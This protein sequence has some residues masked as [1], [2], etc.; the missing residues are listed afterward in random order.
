MRRRASAERVPVQMRRRASLERLEK[1]DAPPSTSVCMPQHASSAEAVRPL[2]RMKPP[3]DA[4]PSKEKVKPSLP[5]KPSPDKK[6]DR[7]PDKSP[8]A[9]VQP[10]PRRTM[11]RMNSTGKAGASQEDPPSPPR[12]KKEPHVRRAPSKT[13]MFLNKIRP[14]RS[15][16]SWG[17]GRAGAKAT[18]KKS[19]RKTGPV[20]PAKEFFYPAKVVVRVDDDWDHL[21]VVFSYGMVVRSIGKSSPL[22]DYLIVGDQVAVFP[23]RIF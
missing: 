3:V 6:A 2:L 4:T 15:R 12:G 17:A 8:T 5:G 22:L 13:K 23:F 21:D 11:R 16:P 14:G 18:K 9:G 20:I 7:K 1:K 19:E 10:S